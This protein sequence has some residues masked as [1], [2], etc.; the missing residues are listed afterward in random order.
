MS[1]TQSAVLTGQQVWNIDA[2]HSE[3]EFAVKH[4]MISTVKGRFG[5]VSGSITLNADD[6]AASRVDADIDVASIDTRQEQRDAHLRSADFFDV[7]NYPVMTFRSRSIEPGGEN[8]FSVTGDLTIRGVTKSV[9]LAV[10]ETGRGG[11][12]WGGQRIGF[13]ART[14]INRSDFGLTWNQA[15]ETG[16]VVVGDDIRINL[17]IEAV[18]A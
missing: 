7:E 17:E 13:T 8:E 3:V 15:L 6:L 2:A 1:A 4:L 18:Q 11:D 10:E 16:G 12:P 5:T 14:K 9:V